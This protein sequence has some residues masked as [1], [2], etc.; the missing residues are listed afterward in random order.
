MAKEVVMTLS[1]GTPKAGLDSLTT[2]SLTYGEVASWTVTTGSKGSLCEISIVTDN[3]RKTYWQLTIGGVVQFT[4]QTIPQ[5]LTFAWPSGN[6]I[7]SETEILVEAASTDGAEVT[8]WA[9]MTMKEFR[10]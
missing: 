1:G 6:D 7:E 8:A 9:S 3:Y 4:N 5:P 2:S 10:E